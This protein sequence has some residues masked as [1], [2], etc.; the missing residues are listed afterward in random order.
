MLTNLR[1]R[2]IEDAVKDDPVFGTNDHV[3]LLLLLAP[4][5]KL[6]YSCAFTQVFARF[7]CD[8]EELVG[9]IYVS[10]HLKNELFFK[11]GLH[12]VWR[13]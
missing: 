13:T 9:R 1:E 5:M 11:V 8:L 6:D 3:L 7:S 10:R 12:R 2:P 4:F